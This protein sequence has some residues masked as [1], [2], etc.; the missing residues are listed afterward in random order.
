MLSIILQGKSAIL[1]VYVDN[2]IIIG[3]DTFE[4]LRLK[5]VVV[6]EFEIKDIGNLKYFLE[7]E[8]ARLK[9]KI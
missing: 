6:K 2:V 7:M 5:K 9:K 8:I 1:I 3:N 4:I